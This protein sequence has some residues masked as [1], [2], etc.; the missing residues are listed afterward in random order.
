MHLAEYASEF[1]ETAVLI[2]SVVGIV[3]V[4]FGGASPVHRAIPSNLA[5]L[6]ITGLLLGGVGW[7]LALSPPGKLSGAHANPAISIGFWLLDKM[8]LR[9]TIGYV[10][11]QMLGAVLGA[12][13]G[14]AVF[15]SLAA[16][17]KN[18]TLQ[19]GQEA[20][21][22]GALFGE[23]GATFVLTFAVYTFLSVKRLRAWTPAMATLLVGVLV[24]VDGNYSGAGMNP[25]R[26]FGPAVTRADW[27]LFWAYS[28]GPVAGAA[29]A[30]LMRRSG[31]LAHPTPHSAKLVHDSGY[32]SIFKHDAVPSTPPSSVRAPSVASTPPGPPR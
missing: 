6:F 2:F 10:A 14:A 30:A 29:L 16:Q 1:I 4:M 28:G 27:T 12:V 15:G 7:L 23:V 11:G 18:A 24:A 26:W 31:L 25:A 13:A 17:V 32:R 22:T 21:A 8:H 9:D 3:S 19:P 20:G 5:R